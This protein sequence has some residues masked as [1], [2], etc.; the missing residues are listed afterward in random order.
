MKDQTYTIAEV[1][2]LVAQIAKLEAEL[3]EARQKADEWKSRFADAVER[4]EGKLHCD[5][6]CKCSGRIE[7]NTLRGLLSANAEPIHPEQS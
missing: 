5:D 3:Q 7:V 2:K 6:D 4:L 1:S